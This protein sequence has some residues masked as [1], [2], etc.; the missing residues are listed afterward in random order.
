[1]AAS[2]Q[3]D[4]TLLLHDFGK[5]DRAAFDALLAHVYEELR[6]IAHQYLRREAAQDALCTTELVHEAYF[7]LIDQTRVAWADRAHFYAVA[8]Q[9]MRRIL[10]DHAR[11]RKADKRGGGQV[12]LS[13][14]ALGD[15]PVD[16]AAELIAL[17]EALT[18]LAAFDAR[19]ARVVECRY[20]AGLTIE[21][22]ADALDVSPSTVKNDWSLAK[23]WLYRAMQQ[24]PVR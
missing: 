12:H 3:A 21:E 23:A 19:A 1:M 14:E 17:D 11:A 5:G 9:A 22:T 20:F 6:R 4:I 7:K 24:D 8:A 15:I 10:I 2:P 16:R 13:I 18:H